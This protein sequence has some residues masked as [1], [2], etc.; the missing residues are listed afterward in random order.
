M[1]PLALI[2]ALLGWPW[3]MDTWMIILAVSQVMVSVAF[4][5]FAIIVIRKIIKETDKV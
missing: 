1:S 3:T 2:L 5:V 4:L